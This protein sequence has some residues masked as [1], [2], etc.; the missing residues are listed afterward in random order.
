MS[1]KLISRIV[2]GVTSPLA[3]VLLILFFVPWVNLT[4]NG[5]ELASASGLQLTV[6]SISPS[7]MLEKQMDKEPSDGEGPDARPW[8]IMGLL[9]P[10]GLLATCALM[11][12]GRFGLAGGGKILIVLGV[13]GLLVM[14]LAANVEYRDEMMEDQASSDSQGPSDFPISQND[15]AKMINT[16]A[17]GAVWTS[18]VL[19]VLI[20]LMG[21]VETFFGP[22]LR[23]LATS[24]RQVPQP[25]QTP[26]QTQDSSMP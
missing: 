7:P 25:E 15:V 17:G 1:P 16:E 19:Y 18:L 20:A 8:F 11:L 12:T 22:M 26:I 21:A 23:G 10:L 14:I 3:L 5:M 2:A 4:C 9:V 24:R 13:V 6:G